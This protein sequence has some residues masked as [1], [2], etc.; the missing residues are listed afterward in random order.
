[1]RR[2]TRTAHSDWSSAHR[3]FVVVFLHSCSDTLKCGS[4]S[5]SF[6]MKLVDTNANLRS[7]KTKISE[8]RLFT[9]DAQHLW[10]P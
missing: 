6:W 3:L 2:V 9:F 7:L 1:M 5:G 8:E 4:T 10:F